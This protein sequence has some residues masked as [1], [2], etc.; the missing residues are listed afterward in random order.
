VR[1]VQERDA[2]SRA[3]AQYTAF[4]IDKPFPEYLHQ[5]QHFLA[6]PG[7]PAVWDWIVVDGSQRV[8]SFCT[9]WS[10]AVSGIGQLDPLGTHPDFQ[11]KGLGKSV[12][13]GCLQYLQSM[14]MHSARVIVEANN[15]AAIR[16][17][18]RVGFCKA[19]KL[20]TYKK[21]LHT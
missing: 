6:S 12:L 2:F 16:L 14:G 3:D 5:Y 8:A 13:E 10:D 15:L 7:Y 11:R 17:Y 1:Q 20:L 19:N 18:E 9:A 4:K 21:S